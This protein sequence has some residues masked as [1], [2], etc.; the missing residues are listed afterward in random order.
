MK[1]VDDLYVVQC[2]GERRVLGEMNCGKL[3][4]KMSSRKYKLLMLCSR[5]NGGVD[6]II[7]SGIESHDGKKFFVWKASCFCFR[8]F[9]I[10]SLVNFRK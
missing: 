8:D 4:S 10:R 5:L 7:F 3:L 1:D 6:V 2:T 9:F